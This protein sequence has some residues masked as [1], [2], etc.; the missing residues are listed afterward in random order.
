MHYKGNDD[1]DTTVSNKG[2][3]ASK[4]H[5]GNDSVSLSLHPNTIHNNFVDSLALKVH[6]NTNDTIFYGDRFYIDKYS[7]H[8]WKSVKAFDTLFYNDIGYY[9]FP[10]TENEHPISLNHVDYI[11]KKGAYRIRKKISIK[12]IKTKKTYY[13]AFEIR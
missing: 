12:G 13:V 3:T 11:F 2:E 6:N 5:V 9:G 7:D 8:E 1:L 10:M 4:E